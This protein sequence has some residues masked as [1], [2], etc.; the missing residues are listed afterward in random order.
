M[1]IKHGLISC[2]SHG[3]LDRDAWTS[4]MSAAKWGDRIPQV[5]ELDNGKGQ[6]V[7]RWSVNGKVQGPGPFAGG[8]VNC[9]A[10]MG[11]PERRTHPQ[12]WEEVP[13]KV[14]DAAARL[15]AL[16]EDGV[17]AEVFYPNNPTSNFGFPTDDP[18]FELDCVHAYNDAICSYRQFS[19]RYIPLA[20]IPYRSPIDTII[21]EITDSVKK[22]AGGVC[23]LTEPSITVP[24]VKPTND[25]FW[26]PFWAAC[27][28]LDI[29]I[30]WHGSGGLV[31][32]L[33]VPLWD[34]FNRS[35]AHTAQTS[36]L[37]V[38]ASTMISNLL[39]SGRLERYPA[40]KWVC[41]ETGMGWLSYVLESCDHEWERRQL[42]REGLETKPSEVFRRQIFADFWF[43]SAGMEV[44]D[45]I[46]ID[47]L[48]WESDFPHV[49][50]T[51]PDSRDWA[52]RVLVGVPE[53]QQRKL[54]W[55][56]AA[57]LYKLEVN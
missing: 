40:L 5:V 45:F 50:A 49:T 8:V 36:R 11:D 47:N 12:R 55:E 30:S 22:G 21:A 46:G 15:Q 2:D 23:M 37:C 42:W 44:R 29:P 6:L 53:D 3:Q 9:P 20:L 52:E 24:G 51:Y 18:D 13:K 4:R 34:G 31:N 16:D 32:Q 41:A 54:R 26:E 28:D 39:F 35:Q 10:A 38:T 48:M 1:Q 14:Y 7:H 25:E 33:A 19:D 43:E 56:N 57:R 17:D 27:Q